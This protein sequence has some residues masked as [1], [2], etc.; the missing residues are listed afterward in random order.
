MSILDTGDIASSAITGFS[1]N[2]IASLSSGVGEAGIASLV[3]GLFPQL[4]LHNSNVVIGRTAIAGTG[5]CLDWA[6]TGSSAGMALN[7]KSYRQAYDCGYPATG[8]WAVQLGEADLPGEDVRLFINI[9]DPFGTVVLQLHGFAT[10]RNFGD[11]LVHGGDWEH[12]LR[13]YAFTGDFFGDVKR[14]LHAPM[15]VGDHGCMQALMA[16]LAE[17]ADW[18]ND[19][20]IDYM[21]VRAVPHAATDDDLHGQ[22]ENSVIRTLAT[23][24]ASYVRDFPINAL[25]SWQQPAG[26]ARDLGTDVARPFGGFVSEDSLPK[27]PRGRVPPFSGSHLADWYRMASARD[28]RTTLAAGIVTLSA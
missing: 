22:T 8:H 3:E 4:S 28:Y 7:N 1:Q 13:V 16:E 21:P 26:A 23:V 5:R 14:V 24:I 18:I 10:D 20:N 2:P 17:T 9:V 6:E 27:A 12:Q 25:V 11:M 15:P 19:A